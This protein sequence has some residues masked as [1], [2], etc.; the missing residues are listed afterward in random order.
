[1]TRKQ[2]AATVAGPIFHEIMEKI[3]S[4]SPEE[5]FTKPEGVGPIIVPDNNATQTA[6][7]IQG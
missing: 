5:H 2:P 6:P 3:L 4:K 7:Q 1:M